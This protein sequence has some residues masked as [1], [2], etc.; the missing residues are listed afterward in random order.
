MLFAENH[1][2]LIDVLMNNIDYAEYN[3]KED[4]KKWIYMFIKESPETFVNVDTDL[5]TITQDRNIA[6]EN[7]PT[8][9]KIIADTYFSGASKL[10]NYKENYLSIFIMYS[11]IVILDSEILIIPSSV[12]KESLFNIIDSSMDLLNMTLTITED[13]LH[14]E[15]SELHNNKYCNCFS[16]LF[17]L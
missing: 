9:V 10:K 13:V 5:Q 6:I 1:N 2:R 17:H 8:L 3:L 14:D 4:E 15:E 7:I 16:T 11:I 12:S